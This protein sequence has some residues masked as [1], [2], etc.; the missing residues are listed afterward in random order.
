MPPSIKVQYFEF[1]FPEVNE[2]GES[3]ENEEAEKATDAVREDSVGVYQTLLENSDLNAAASEHNIEIKT[4]PYILQGK[5]SPELRWSFPFY[6]KIFQLEIDEI[7][8]PYEMGNSMVIAKL[9][10]KRNA[11]IPELNEVTTDVKEAYVNTQARILARKKATELIPKIREKY[12]LSEDKDFN[13]IVDEIGLEIQQTPLFQREM[14][15]PTIGLSNE[16]QESAFKLSTENKLSGIVRTKPGF[17]IL[18]LDEYKSVNLDEF[19]KE[20][21]SFKK[22]LA[23]QRTGE[24]YKNFLAKLR[25]QSNLEENIS[26]LRDQQNQR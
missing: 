19:D 15:L 23:D 25:V 12:R 24:I 3:E 17:C 13:G 2:D 5:Q 16:F 1:S 20:K 11:Y 18:H 9:I 14:Y 6:S 7:T 21:E 10:E 8:E 26:K 4:S 22:T